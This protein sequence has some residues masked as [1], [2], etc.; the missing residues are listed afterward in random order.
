MR[1]RAEWVQAIESVFH[2]SWGEPETRREA[3]HKEGLEACG[4]LDER[5]GLKGE[6]STYTDRWMPLQG[7]PINSEQEILLCRNDS[8]AYKSI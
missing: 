6:R 4:V 8:R 1:Q 5:V 2:C 3:E 7:W